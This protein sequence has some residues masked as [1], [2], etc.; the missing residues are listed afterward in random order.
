[1][2]RMGHDSSAAALIYQHA[3]R[4]ADEAIATALEGRLS[5]ARKPRHEIERE[6]ER[7]S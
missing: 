3:T 5:K 7:D 1:M 4:E 2:T 6:I